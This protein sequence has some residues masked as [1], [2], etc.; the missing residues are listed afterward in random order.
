METKQSVV[1]RLDE[2]VIITMLAV[3]VLAVIIFAFRYKNYEPCRPFSIR[4]NAAH[5]HT[6]EVIRFE[7]DARSFGKLQWNFGD[8]QN[9]ETRIA[10]AVHAYDQAGEYT[11]ALSSDGKC[12][13]YKT[14][15]ITPAPKV[16]NPL[17]IPTFAYPQSAEVGKPVSFL[18]TTTGARSWEWRFG[19]TATV[20]ATTS[21][22]TYTYTSP[23]LKTVSLVVNGDPQQMAV[24]KVFVNPAP[25][26]PLPNNNK[27]GGGGG[28]PIIVI[29]DRPQ[30][31][32]LDQQNNPK[33]E[34]LPEVPD[35]TKEQ[36]E[37]E[38]RLVADK[39][40]TVQSFLPYLCG[41]TN[42]QVSLNGSET[43][44]ADLCNKLAELKNS[45]K[46][47]ELNVQM[48]KNERHCIVALVVYLKKRENIFEKVF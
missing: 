42:I 17:L 12:T 47:K 21:N 6:G 28:R 29:A 37:K 45:K 14:L 1:S 41:N 43:T 5:Y 26:K 3:S 44:F 34:P 30:N 36:I 4:T 2:N 23:G 15:L 40:R 25:P 46:I 10:S 16:V 35:I 24:A 13:Q 7:T 48:V 18:D 19:E 33:V 20:D 38:L 22:P 8:N 9:N 11:V 27:G 32:P 31:N 39:Q